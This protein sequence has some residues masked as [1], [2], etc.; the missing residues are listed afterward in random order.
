MLVD[1]WTS[2][3]DEKALEVEVNSLF[4]NSLISTTI[5]DSGKRERSADSYYN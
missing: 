5:Q 2:L 1:D 3:W 4:T